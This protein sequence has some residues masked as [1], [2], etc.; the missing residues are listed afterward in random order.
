MAC[1]YTTSTFN[2]IGFLNIFKQ[3][4][5]EGKMASGT[6]LSFRLWSLCR[7]ICIK[8]GLWRFGHNIYTLWVQLTTIN[9][10]RDVKKR[11]NGW[12]DERYIK[13]RQFKDVHKGERCFIV[14]TG[15][16]L[17]L[18]DINKLKE[19][20][21]I[22]LSM[23]SI[24]KML[25]KTEW[26]PTYYTVNDPVAFDCM[27]KEPLFCEIETRFVGSTLSNFA[28]FQ[29]DDFVLPVDLLEV[30]H[31]G[32]AKTFS[33]NIYN[34]VYTGQTVTYMCMQIAAYMGFKE[35]YLL[36]CDCD[37]GGANKHFDDKGY[38]G[39]Y[40][41]IDFEKYMINTYKVAQAYCEAHDD[42]KIY[43]ATRGGK[44]EVFPRVDFDSLFD[45]K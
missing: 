15:P 25:D 4:V 8:L 37:Y 16:S 17:T 31:F 18:E 6:K 29:K 28:S 44:V 36:G 13:L 1:N 14:C 41:P 45:E 32:Y 27:S 5:E 19:N 24:I 35:V 38:D 33:D 22:C 34:I 7:N 40:L 10:Y 23:N 43:N 3:P 30:L 26:R 42:F 21:E 2:M 11:A 20:N 39:I 9:F 12:E